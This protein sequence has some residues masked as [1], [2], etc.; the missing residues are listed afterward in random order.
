MM[1]LRERYR[2]IDFSVVYFIIFLI[3]INATNQRKLTIL[4]IKAWNKHMKN[5][6]PLKSIHLP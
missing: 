1:Y 6:R 4:I 5:R 3:L 2:T